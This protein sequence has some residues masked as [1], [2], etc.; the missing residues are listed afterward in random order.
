MKQFT[1]RLPDELVNQLDNL[2]IRGIFSSRSEAIREG[3]RLLLNHYKEV[4]RDA[5]RRNEAGN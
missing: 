3:I 4:R 5:K 2:V 1:I